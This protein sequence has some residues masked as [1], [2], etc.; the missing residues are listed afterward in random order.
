VAQAVTSSG[1]S[2]SLYC[3]FF[4]TCHPIPGRFEPSNHNL[5]R[6]RPLLSFGGLQAVWASPFG[7]PVRA[8]I[9]LIKFHGCG[10]GS[11]FVV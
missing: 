9:P 1:K 11:G 3:I 4:N 6:L 5:Q 10:L 7:R 2:Q 8:R